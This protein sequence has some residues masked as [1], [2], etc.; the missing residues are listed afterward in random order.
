[1]VVVMLISFLGSCSKA[2]SWCRRVCVYAHCGAAVPVQ[3]LSLEEL[4]RKKKEQQ[5]QEAKVRA[6]SKDQHRPLGHASMSATR[7][8]SGSS[9]ALLC[10]LHTLC[11]LAGMTKS[12]S[13]HGGRKVRKV[14]CS[15]TRHR[16][17]LPSHSRPQ[18]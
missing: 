6:F 14:V 7:Q 18:P 11:H 15:S 8:F 3:P 2:A 16:L 10:S 9:T 17:I 4:L 13:Q 1:M 5:E 12:A